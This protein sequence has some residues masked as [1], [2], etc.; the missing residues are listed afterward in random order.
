MTG[1]VE[2]PAQHTVVTDEE[3]GWLN[4]RRELLAPVLDN[5]D[6]VAGVAMDRLLAGR[7]EADVERACDEIP[8]WHYVPGPESGSLWRDLLSSGQTWWVYLGGRCVGTAE[9]DDQGVLV[10]H[11][12][13]LL[14]EGDQA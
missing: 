6:Q 7:S 9:H 10:I 1:P 13:P 2:M 5:V 14:W 4:V 8:M 12:L 11:P 3:A